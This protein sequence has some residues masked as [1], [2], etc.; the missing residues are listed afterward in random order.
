VPQTDANFGIGTLAKAD[1]MTSDT[2][3][4]DERA[5]TDAP[6]FGLSG[7]LLLLT[8]LFV[9]LAEGA[10][11]CSLDAN[12]R[13]SFLA[14]RVAVARTVS[15][16]LSAS[17]DEPEEPNDPNKDKVQAPEK[18]DPGHSR[19]PLAPRT[20]RD[21][22]G[23]PA[24]AARRAR[25][26]ARDPSRGRPAPIHR[27]ARRV[28]ALETLFFCSDSRRDAR[29]GAGAAPAQDFIEILIEEGPLRQRWCASRAT[30]CC[31]RC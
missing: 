19:Q 2:T 8:V 14:D 9:M 13:L 1:L 31:S 23:Q 18:G 3:P 16:V 21:Q 30:S 17:K 4:Q 22:D 27:D 12:F 6:R 26:A 28:A 15:I 29:G 10:D 7:K 11:L 24:Q 5:R 20:V 25:H